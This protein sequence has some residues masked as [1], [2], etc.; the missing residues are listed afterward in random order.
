M[1]KNPLR[2]LIQKN[3]N[4]IDLLKQCPKINEFVSKDS[5]NHFEK[6]LKGLD[7]NKICFE[8]R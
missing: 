4:I 7:K 8:K 1:E 2:I 6:I 3:Q 5:R